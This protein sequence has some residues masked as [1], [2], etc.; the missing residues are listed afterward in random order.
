MFLIITGVLQAQG[1]WVQK[2]DYGGGPAYMSVG[3]SIGNK[4]YVGTGAG[5]VND[6]SF[7]EYD[8]ATDAWAQKADFGGGGRGDA[9][10]FSIGTKGYI[11]TGFDDLGTLYHDFWEYDPSTNLW[12]RKA[13]MP[14]VPRRAAIGMMIGGRGYIGSGYAGPSNLKQDF[15]EYDPATDAWS[16]KPNLPYAF[17][18]GI[19]FSISNKGFVG[20][21]NNGSSTPD[22]L[23]EFDPFWNAWTQKNNMPYTELS[24]A[25]AFSIGTTG[26]VTLGMNYQ[27]MTSSFPND[28]WAYDPST[29]DWYAETA[30]SGI[31][32][33]G[34]VA[35]TIGNSGYVCTGYHPQ[36]GGSRSDH[37]QFTPN[38]KVTEVSESENKLANV[39]VLPN[40]C[41]M[42]STFTISFNSDFP[43]TC[44]FTL[45]DSRGRMVQTSLV[46][47]TGNQT[48]FVF[49]RGNLESGMYTYS[50]NNR[51]T[52]FCSG[53][54]ILQ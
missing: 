19:C 41:T 5:C 32:R 52:I 2:C 4:G 20:M 31:A 22:E 16:Q 43:S 53:N 21:G 49:N 47:F 14:G 44:E 23:W 6:D 18:D 9:V 12:T 46:E 51:S 24:H 15:W 26:Y 13:D 40:P 45:F 37:W 30:F 33:W 7:W 3:F 39:S 36:Q 17:C 42:Q 29:D 28:C 38:A 54:L 25:V 8:P 11:G 27:A 10:G 34:A 1:D 48:T 50:L 35:F